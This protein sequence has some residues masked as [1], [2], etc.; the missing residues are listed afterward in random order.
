MCRTAMY[1]TG[2][3]SM[4]EGTGDPTSKT[5]IFLEVMSIIAQLKIPEILSSHRT[6]HNSINTF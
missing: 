2:L 5:D 1:R 6:V 4:V 3:W